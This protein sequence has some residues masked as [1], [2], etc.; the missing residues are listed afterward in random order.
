MGG[1]GGSH[2]RSSAASGDPIGFNRLVSEVA[3][4]ERRFRKAGLPLLIEGYSATEDVFTRALPLLTLVFLIE[5]L[6]AINLEWS[7]A[8]NVAA[9]IGGIALL[10]GTFGVINLIR[11]RPFRSVPRK[12]GVP[13]LSIF[14]LLP[15]ILPLLFG[16]QLGSAVI[17]ASGNLL[18]LGLIYLVVGYGVGSIIRWTGH[19]FMS[20]LAASLTL[21]VRALP[22][23]LFF[24]LVTFFT[25][26]YWQMFASATTPRYVGVVVLFVGLAA[27]FLLVRLPHSVH[28][29][30]RE[31]DLADLPLRRAQR[32]NIALVIFVSQV[33]QV[34]F[35][36]LAIW[37]FFVLFGALLV[38]GPILQDWIGGSGRELITL[39]FFGA[40]VRVTEELLRVSTGIAVF[41]GL[42]YAVA[43][44][45][46]STYRDE[47][48]NEMTEEMRV[49]FGA[50][51][52]YLRLLR[53]RSASAGASSASRSSAGG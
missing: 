53:E 37:L 1:T 45:V 27:L 43:M 30:V 11:L 20:Q 13:E 35:V 26:E 23:L 40:Q 3:S 46:D 9:F 29:L 34:A 39:P 17:T 8:A 31:V 4:Y 19:R 51:A 44:V 22:L 15:S 6:G 41:S 38:T 10:L 49:T 21:L 32:V 52:E 16:G 47:F 25:N 24:A 5:I 18:L 12:V 2:E 7:L 48:V 42:Y 14:V 36:V 50:R 33:L 28:E